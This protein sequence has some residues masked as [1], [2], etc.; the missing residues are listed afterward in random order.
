MSEIIAFE[1]NGQPAKVAARPGQRLLDLLRGPLRLTGTKEGCSEGE[2]GA[3]TVMVDG[4][5][6][7]SCLYPALEV[8][9][10]EVTT[11][12]GLRVQD[13]RLSAAQQAFADAAGTQCGF[14]S[15]GMVLT[16]A[17]LLAE[18]TEPSDEQIRD[19]LVGNLCRC[20]GYVQIVESVRIAAERLRGDA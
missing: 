17:A 13:N 18:N 14:C 2:C 10:R 1:L 19:A 3:C 9:G 11:I 5:P 12:E 6:I 16:A 8:D 4:R 7:N 15:P 20:T